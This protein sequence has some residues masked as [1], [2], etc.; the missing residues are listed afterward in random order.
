MRSFPPKAAVTTSCWSFNR[1]LRLTSAGWN[2]DAILT[3][4]LMAASE[5][6]S[7]LLHNED[8]IPVT[9]S[10]VLHDAL[11]GRRQLLHG[12]VACRIP[13]MT[14]IIPNWVSTTV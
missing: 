8:Q 5:E 7:K 3:V 2:E 14:G 12:S 10:S 11:P 6:P 4:E 1:R 9:G 13:E